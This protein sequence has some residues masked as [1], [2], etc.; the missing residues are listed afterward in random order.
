MAHSVFVSVCV[1]LCLC[2][3]LSVCVIVYLCVWLCVSVYLRFVC[4]SICVVLGF[5]SLS[6]HLIA[7]SIIL[8]K[9]TIAKTRR[10]RTKEQSG[11]TTYSTYYWLKIMGSYRI[12]CTML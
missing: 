4:F 5:R 12:I 11:Q 10:V 6:A 2:L 3:C 1:S 9:L 7:H 8:D